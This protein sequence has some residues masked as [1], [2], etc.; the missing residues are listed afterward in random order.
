MSLH[1]E[2]DG[3][4][5]ESKGSLEPMINVG[6]VPGSR[7]QV[8]HGVTKASIMIP[9]VTCD[10]ASQRTTMKQQTASEIREELSDYLFC[11][12]TTVYKSRQM[13][14]IHL[15]PSNNYVLVVKYGSWIM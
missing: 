11:K 7:I 3:Q 1:P 15:I 8:W 13:H 10:S 14:R 2:F 12:K 4:R 5:D 6:I 9:G